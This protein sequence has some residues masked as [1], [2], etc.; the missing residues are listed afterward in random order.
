MLL[1]VALLPVQMIGM[2]VPP[3]DDLAAP[4]AGDRSIA[5]SVEKH[6]T[7]LV[8]HAV[9]ISAGMFWHPKTDIASGVNDAVRT[10]REGQCP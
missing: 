6:D 5:D 4:V 10:N 2:Q 8:D 9:H 7:M 3:L 1:I